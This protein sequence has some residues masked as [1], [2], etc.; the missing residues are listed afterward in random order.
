V[1]SERPDAQLASEPEPLDLF[2]RDNT[3]CM[4]NL[5]QIV[6]DLVGAYSDLLEIV[7]GLSHELAATSAQVAA[8]QAER[9]GASDPDQAA[10][11]G[12][13]AART[14]RQAAAL[15]ERAAIIV[16]HSRSTNSGAR[17]PTPLRRVD[18]HPTASSP[19]RAAS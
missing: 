5:L 16:A 18:D 13:D 9:D 2:I 1:A 17:P 11:I 15:A 4:D 8:L 12:A 7:D 6:T 10:E 14:L 3:A 19:R